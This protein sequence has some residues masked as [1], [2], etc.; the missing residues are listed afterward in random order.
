[1]LIGRCRNGSIGAELET[2]AEVREEK[3]KMCHPGQN[4]PGI[5]VIFFLN[6]DLKLRRIS[7][8]VLRNKGKNEPVLDVRK[9]RKKKMHQEV[10]NVVYAP[11]LHYKW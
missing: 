1:M 10:F 8:K 7:P 6:A 11:L 3:K 4:N 2:A 5:A 9:N